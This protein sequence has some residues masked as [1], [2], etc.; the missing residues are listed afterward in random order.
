MVYKKGNNCDALWDVG[1]GISYCLE[2]HTKNDKIRR[3]LKFV[4]LK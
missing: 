4:K 2:C 3:K 1:N